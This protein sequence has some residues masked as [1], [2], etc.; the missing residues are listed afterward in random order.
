MNAI[1]DKRS[2]DEVIADVCVQIIRE[3]LLYFSEADVQQML[4]QALNR[5]RALHVLV[6][7]SVS[8]GSI[9]KGMYHT[10]LVHREYG[11]EEGRRVDVVIFDP[12]DVAKIN[13]TN[14]KIGHS[15]LKPLYAFEIGTEKTSDTSTHLKKDL[16]KLKN[17][18]DTGYIIHF[19]KDTTLA[20]TGSASRR[21]TE[22]KIDQSFKAA[23]H[24]LRDIVASNIRV[25]AILVRTG[26][27]QTG[28]RG[29]CEVFNQ[30]NE[31]WGKVNVK[32]TDQIKTAILKQLE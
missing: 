10:N 12:D 1:I 3:P 18:K 24:S 21:R 11:G 23:F 7:T 32:R 4:V 14:L 22:N 16:D 19:F 6:E 28:M 8:R 2:I 31:T 13:C 27:K 20:P 29:K 26:R 17:I 25:L 30:Q 5:I 9:S 15:Y